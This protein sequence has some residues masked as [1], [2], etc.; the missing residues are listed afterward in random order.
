MAVTANQ[1]IKAQDAENLRSGLVID[2]THFYE[3]TLCFYV[4]ASGHITN[5]I[6]TT[7]N[8]F[9][10]IVRREV[11]NTLTGHA[12][13]G[14]AIEYYTEG[15]F[16]LPLPSA[17]QVAVGDKVYAVDNYVLSLTSTNQPPVGKVVGYEDTA[18]VWVQIDPMAST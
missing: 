16:L 8:W 14:K 7:V 15:C 17:T 18:H 10:G 5:V 12:A 4:A 11:D 13:G 6:S 9:A 2:N 1:I 3:G